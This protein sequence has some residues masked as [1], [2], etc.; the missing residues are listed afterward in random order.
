M[1]TNAKKKFWDWF[2][3]LDCFFCSAPGSLLCQDCRALLDISSVHQQFSSK[4]LADLYVAGSYQNRF[5][6]KMVRVFKYEPFVKEL[7][8]PL[9][10][11]I[12]DHLA[13]LE[14]K[15]DFSNFVLVPVP[16]SDKRMRWRG[17]NQAGL[18]AD[19]LSRL[20]NLP[21]TDC[22]VKIRNGSPQADLPAKER[23]TSVKG[24]IACRK[25]EQILSKKILLIDDVFTT[26]ATMEECGR[27]LL[28]NGAKTVVGIAV[29]GS[30]S[31]S[32]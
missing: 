2:L 27:I 8:R 11:L 25:T 24:T 1:W 6:K 4:I 31:F 20:M 17:F 32:D 19:E 16:L 22:L 29:A 13:L 14:T 7:K 18:L 21:V 23:K 10:S 15:P 26:G 12:F 9:A 30:H 28:K 3:P 5:T